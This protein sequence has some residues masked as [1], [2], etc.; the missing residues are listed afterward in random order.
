[1]WR[2]NMS[3][4]NGVCAGTTRVNER[5]EQIERSEICEWSEYM[6]GTNVANEMSVVSE[7]IMSEIAFKLAEQ[8]SLREGLIQI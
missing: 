3:V 2:A 4:A 7:V 5:N 8:L 6:N 1:M